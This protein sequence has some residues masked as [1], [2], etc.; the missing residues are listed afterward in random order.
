MNASAG[1]MST[2]AATMRARREAVCGKVMID[3]LHSKEGA[4]ITAYYVGLVAVWIAD[5]SAFVMYW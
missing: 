1:L 3:I 4:G 2:V 5:E